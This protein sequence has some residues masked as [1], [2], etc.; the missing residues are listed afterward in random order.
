MDV[1]WVRT[2]DEEDWDACDEKN[3]GYQYR[4][5]ESKKKTKENIDRICKMG[6]KRKSSEWWGHGKIRRDPK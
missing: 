5:I 2:T 1:W 3:D 6:Y 4:W